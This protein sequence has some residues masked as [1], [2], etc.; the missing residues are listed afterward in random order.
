MHI[1]D[2]FQTEAKTKAFIRRE[3]FSSGRCRCPCCGIIRRLSVLGDGRYWCGVCRRKWSLKQ[4]CGVGGSKLTCRQ[5]SMLLYCFLNNH[6]LQSAMDMAGVSYPTVRR[7]YDMM[8]RKAQTYVEKRQT[9]KLQGIVATDACYVGK[10]RNNNQAIVL[11]VVQSNY[12]DIAFRIV[13]EEEQGYVEKFLYDTTEKGAHIIH[14]GHHAYSDLTWCGYTHQTEYHNLNQFRFTSAI[15]RI[16]ALL[17][18]FLR[19]RYHHITKEKLPGYLAE[20]QYKFLYRKTHKNQQQFAQFL[21]TPV[22]TA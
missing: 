16:W 14:D 8:R 17:K 10:Q 1:V 6:T 13:P 21:F 11:G 9:K 20:F 15:E 2:Q 4:L 3:L 7:Y 5:V 12:Q 18:T 19:R 22:P